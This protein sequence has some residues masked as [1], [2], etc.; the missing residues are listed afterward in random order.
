MNDW[1]KHVALR[2]VRPVQPHPSGADTITI[3]LPASTMTF[4][5]LDPGVRAAL[6][7]V[8]DADTLADLLAAAGPAANLGRL[9][10][11]LGRLWTRG[12]L[13]FAVT[14]GDEEVCSLA[15]STMLSTWRLRFDDVTGPYRLSRFALVRRGEDRPDRPGG[16]VIESLGALAR[17]TLSGPEPAALLAALH[18][19]RTEAEL[20]QACTLP[21]P[22]LAACLRLLHTG[23][24]VGLVDGDGKLPEDR[25]PALAVLEPHDVYL[26][27]R[28]RRRLTPDPVGGTYPDHGAPALPALREPYP[29][30]AIPL[31][32]PDLAAL[33]RTDPPLTEVME[34]RRSRRTWA[35][36]ALTRTELGEFLHRVFHIQRFGPANPDDPHGYD[37]TLRAIPSAGATHDLEV[38]LAAGRVAGLDRGLYHYDPRGHALTEVSTAAYAVKTILKSASRSAEIETEPPAVLVLASRFGRLAWKYEGMALAATLK[39]VGVAYE[40]MYLAATAM[41]LAGCGLGS[42]DAIAFGMATGNRPHAES[43]VGEFMLGPAAP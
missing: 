7:A 23:G 6:L 16:L 18:A 8:A 43:P 39:N 17:M 20:T 36:R 14:D 24:V 33:A 13:G 2:R 11:E 38:Y 10:T 40:A 22:V 19:P 26:H 27:L 42:G 12:V 15:P 1:T 21:V 5:R 28:S 25:D 37:A 30:P 41:G 35:D 4:R 31:P 29:G 3:T 9:A 32:R 34:K